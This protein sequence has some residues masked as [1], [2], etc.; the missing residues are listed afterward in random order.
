MMGGIERLKL[1]PNEIALLSS[2]KIRLAT[3]VARSS[4]KWMALSRKVSAF[5]RLVTDADYARSR[6]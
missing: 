3:C 2:V 1:N 4:Q 5:A 6:R